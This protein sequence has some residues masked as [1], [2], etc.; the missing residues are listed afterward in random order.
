MKIVVFS[1]SHGNSDAVSA[2][3]RKEN[4]ADAFIFL[5]DGTDDL[6]MAQKQNLISQPLLVVRGNCDRNLRIP[7]E[8]LSGFEDKLLFFTHGNGYEVKWTLEGLKQAAKQR[9]V[10][11]V[12]FGHTHVPY[13]EEDNG[14][15]YFN[16]G[17]VA[18]PRRGE[19]TYG[20]LTLNKNKAPQFTHKEVF[21]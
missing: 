5:G 3:F 19:A 2:I 16:P 4:D 10:E 1:D 14:I 17:S 13:L 7:P 15:Y 8:Q 20:V 12:L 6:R 11:I 9:D 18:L 21:E